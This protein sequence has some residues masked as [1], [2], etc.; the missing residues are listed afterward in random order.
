MKRWYVIYTKPKS[1]HKVALW[2]SQRGIESYLPE[3]KISAS[4]SIAS[5]TKEILF[6]CYIF[7]KFSLED[8][9]LSSLQWIPGARKI[10]S[11]DG[12]PAM[13][14]DDMINEIRKNVEL[15]SEA[16]RKHPKSAI[17]SG[18][19]VRIIEG[20]FQNMRAIFERA[21]S[22]RERVQ[23]LLDILGS[24]NRVNIDVDAL[25][26]IS[27]KQISCSNPSYKKRP[28]YTRGHGRRIKVKK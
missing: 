18:T 15:I 27:D 22:S 1:E 7:V 13:I 20:P 21:T 8:E 23:I 24:L 3:L 25:E 9:S 2:L 5:V 11:F 28:R 4:S 26:I 10:I 12:K 14:P 19:P 17:K 6:P 16:K